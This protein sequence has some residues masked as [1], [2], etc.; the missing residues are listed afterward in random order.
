[1]G[2]ELREKSWNKSNLDRKEYKVNNSF[3]VDV[4]FELTAVVK[5]KIIS[6]ASDNGVNRVL[7]LGENQ[8]TCW[9]NTDCQGGNIWGP[10]VTSVPG[11]SCLRKMM[12]FFQILLPHLVASASWLTYL[13]SLC[14]ISH[15]LNLSFNF[16]YLSRNVF[17]LTKL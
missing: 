5:F 16:N 14:S 2:R 6:V 15:M 7:S 10:R 13:V 4:I 8:V 9:G 1:M 12:I 11:Q 3:Y 17:I